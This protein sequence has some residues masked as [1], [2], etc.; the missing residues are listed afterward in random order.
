[1]IHKWLSAFEEEAH[2][3]KGRVRYSSAAAEENQTIQKL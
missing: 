3:N 2:K 1:M